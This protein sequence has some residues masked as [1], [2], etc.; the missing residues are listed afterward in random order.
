MNI[1]V[2]GAGGREHAICWKLAQSK[3]VDKLYC[4]PGNAGIASVAQCVEI[5]VEDIE[6]LK[7]FAVEN[8]IDLAI[9]GPEIPLTLG[10]SDA[11]KVA[12]IKVFGPDAYAAQL[13]GSKVF[14]KEFM[15][16]M[17]IPTADYKVFEDYT[18]A[19]SYLNEIGYPAVIKADGL[20]AGKGVCVAGDKKEAQLFLRQVMVDRVFGSSGD[21]VLVEKCLTGEEAS[22]LAIT[23][24]KDIIVL[25]PAQDHKRA[26]DNDE[27]PNTGGMGAYS[28]VS[29]VPAEIIPE[30]VEKTLRPAVEGMAKRGH[31]F[32]GVLYAGLMLT[33]DGPK[34]LE[35][36]VRFG[37]PEAQAVIPLIEGDLAEICLAAADGHLAEAKCD[38]AIRAAMCVVMVSGGYPGPYRKGMPI[39]GLADAGSMEDVVVFHA[40]T[41]FDNGTIVASGGRVLG[42]TALGDTLRDAR[43]KAYEAVSKICWDTVYFRRDIGKR[44]LDRI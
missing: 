3:N 33:A 25:T 1:L 35:Y 7:W 36:N 40:G 15:V 8:A 20:A 30:I 22:I 6:G 41:A 37:D 12:G 26:F 16:E 27:G 13:E 18:A 9:I 38:P 21:R 19:A 34:V 29:T 24:G 2:I 17:G 5:K 4:A 39:H 42:V 44:D 23:D 32:V 10:V 31:P 43:N 11:L 28:P 14:A